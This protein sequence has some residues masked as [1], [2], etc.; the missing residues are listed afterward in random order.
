MS[1][2]EE[3]GNENERKD[4]TRLFEAIGESQKVVSSL[5][6]KLCFIIFTMGKRG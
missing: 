4:Q 5:Q 2:L 3:T 6:T 1:R